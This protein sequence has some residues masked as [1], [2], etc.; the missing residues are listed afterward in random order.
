MEKQKYQHGETTIVATPGK[1]VRNINISLYRPGKPSGFGLIA[2]GQQSEE[3]NAQDIANLVK[4]GVPADGRRV[5]ASGQGRIILPVEVTLKIDA[6]SVAAKAE[7]EG[8]DAL[9]KSQLASID[10]LTEL[11]AALNDHER[12]AEQFERMMDDEYND[13]VR[14]PRPAVGNVDELRARYPRAAAYVLADSW[15]GAAHDVKASAGSKARRQILEGINHEQAITEM[16]QTWTTHC[17][18]HA[19][20]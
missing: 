5:F 14:P 18:Q 11:Q 8:A 16:R 10:G 13:G 19:W 4:A 15:A 1:G 7:V 2:L 12:Y 3:L 9:Y 17:D 20:D 6:L